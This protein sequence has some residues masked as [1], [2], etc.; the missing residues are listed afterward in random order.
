MRKGKPPEMR[1]F[2]DTLKI[3]GVGAKGRALW[4]WLRA[5]TTGENA[6]ATAERIS[7]ELNLSESGNYRE[8]R[9]LITD[10]IRKEH[11]PILSSPSENDCGYR[12]ARSGSELEE[13]A[14]R[15]LGQAEQIT[16]RANALLRAAR[17][18]QL[19]LEYEDD[20]TTHITHKTQQ[21]AAPTQFVHRTL[22]DLNITARTDEACPVTGLYVCV[23]CTT[24]GVR[25]ETAEE[26][27]DLM[28]SCSQ[29]DGTT[30]RLV[31][32]D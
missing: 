3:T 27:G 14:H 11:A 1:L 18:Y 25:N 19:P 5:N 9:Q 17:R 6:A 13:C 8:V 32:I 4:D 31:Q 23:P 21:R 22:A 12:I 15:L 29:H 10:L 7:T 16:L 24:I 30:W 26:F 28:P 2:A 20:E